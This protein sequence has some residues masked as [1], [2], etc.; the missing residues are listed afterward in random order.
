MCP[1]QWVAPQKYKHQANS[2]MPFSQAE[3]SDAVVF[4]HSIPGYQPTPLRLLPQLANHLGVGAIMIKDESYR[5]GLNSFKALGCSYT[6]GRY[7]SRLVDPSS[8]GCLSFTDIR[9]ARD[10]SVLGE[11]TFVT[12]TDG[13]HGRGVAW[14]AKMLGH[15]AV[16]YLS[17]GAAAARLWAIREL[18]A[19]AT[20]TDLN[21]DDAGRHAAEQAERHGW[22]LVQDTAWDGYTEIPGWIMQ[23]YA[24]VM[25]EAIGQQKELGIERPTH[26]L[27]QAGVGSFAGAAA[28]A[29]LSSGAG[30]DPKI[31]IVEPDQADCFYR[32]ALAG[33]GRPHAVTGELATIMAGLAC[34]EPNPI[35]WNLLRDHADCFVSCSDDVA[36]TGMRIL[37]NP[38]NSDP[39]VV[40]GESGAATMGFLYAV[41]TSQKMRELRE[42]LSLGPDSRVLLVSTEGDTDPANYRHVVWEGAYPAAEW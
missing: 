6:M 41:L 1:V 8:H 18:G 10:R 37:G 31:I 3:L 38:L 39:R 23:G 24:T 15:K 17:K 25:A 12:A 20:V 13:N 9:S 16:V 4:H 36:A 22:V 26:I 11:I 42:R 40:A 5:F 29:A 27:L 32:S 28:A 33:D 21:Y 19:E 34:G 14:A 2:S 7:L 30:Y 35:A